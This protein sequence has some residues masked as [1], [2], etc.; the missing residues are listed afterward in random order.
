MVRKPR[1]NFVG[2]PQHVIQLC[3]NRELCFRMYDK[4]E[5]IL[6]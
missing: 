2:M 1:F 4:L 3:N 6:L 5:A